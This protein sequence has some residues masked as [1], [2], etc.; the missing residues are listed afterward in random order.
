M[1]SSDL[2]ALATLFGILFAHGLLDLKSQHPA[3]SWITRALIACSLLVMGLALS[4]PYLIALIGSFVLLVA[5]A[6]VGGVFIA[7]RWHDG[8]QPAKLFALGWSA[9]II[10]SLFS[11]VSGTGLIANSLLTLHAQQIGSLLEMVIFS[12]ALGA[13]IRQT[14]RAEQLA[15]TQLLANEQQL[16]HEQA[17]SLKLQHEINESLETRVQE[18]T[19]SLQTA[20]HEL[21][22]ANQKLAE[23]N[24]HDGLTGLLN[25]QVLDD[26]L[27][28]MLA[29]AK[30]SGRPIE[31]G[32]ASC[33]E[34]V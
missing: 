24:R 15:Q 1:C 3:Y 32:R 18:R 25:R 28:R 19:T 4:A 7:L 11:V 23:L 17:K 9:L 20:L 13:R 8:Y 33:R 29:Q 6:L 5:C 34:I 2:S 22:A 26:G 31:I 16:R 12:L 10:A 21:S 30:R 27:E 14:Q